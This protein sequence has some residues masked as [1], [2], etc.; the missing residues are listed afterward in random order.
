MSPTCTLLPPCSSLYSPGPEALVTPSQKIDASGTARVED[1][2][3]SIVDWEVVDIAPAVAPEK[4][5]ERSKVALPEEGVTTGVTEKR[6]EVGVQ[7]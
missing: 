4:M 5:N 6:D 2:A 1:T 7:V 3:A